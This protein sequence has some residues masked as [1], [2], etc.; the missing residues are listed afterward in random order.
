MATHSNKKRFESQGPP[1]FKDEPIDYSY[2]MDSASILLLASGVLHWLVSQSLVLA[3]VS[4]FDENGNEDTMGSSSTVGYSNIAVV[5]VI[6]V[7]GILLILVNILG[8][9]RFNMGVPLA[10]TC[11]AAISAACHRPGNDVDDG[12]QP[13]MWSAVAKE[14]LVGHC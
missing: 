5:A 7:G 13:I 6:A 14:G 11:S 2:R 12:T 4:V 8:F 10:G 9:R 1:V 3:R